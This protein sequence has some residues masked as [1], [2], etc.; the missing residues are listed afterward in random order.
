MNSNLLVFVLSIVLVLI[1]SLAL[2]TNMSVKSSKNEIL[3]IEKEIDN[4][5]IVIKRQRIE[6]SSLS[7]PQLILEYIKKND[8]KSFRL[9]NI[10]TIYLE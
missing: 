4:L 3:K 5:K 9:R 8:L 2:F 10:L 6:I 1:F 7:N